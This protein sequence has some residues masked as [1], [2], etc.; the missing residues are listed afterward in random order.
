MLNKL[1][2]VAFLTFIF[3]M[4]PYIQFMGATEVSRFENRNLQQKPDMTIDKLVD[5]KY[6]EQF[7]QYFTDQFPGRNVWV[8]AYLNF[9]RYT[10]KT[11]IYDYYITDKNWIMP[12]P[13]TSY[14]TKDMKTAVK[15][16][17][18]VDKTAEK[19][20]SQLIYVSLPHKVNHVDVNKP[21]YI[22][23]DTGIKSKNYMMEQLAQTDVEVLDIGK[24][25]EKELTP[26][27]INSLYYKTD[28][29][30]NIDGAFYAFE[31]LADQLE[32][33]VDESDY[34]EKCFDDKSFEGS[35]NRQLYMMVDASNENMCIKYPEEDFDSFKVTTNGKERSVDDVFALAKDREDKLVEYKHLFTGDYAK[36]SIENPR[37]D[38]DKKVLISKDSYT[39]PMVSLIAQKFAKTDVIDLRHYKKK[40]FEQLI[41]ENDYDYVLIMINDDK[42]TGPV[43]NFD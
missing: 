6:M 29:H 30:W 26:E 35:Y 3:I 34:A 5:G 13:D 33:P 15:H 11:F 16:L 22:M 20:G 38:N 19:A 4:A 24:K 32:M 14:R 25:M 36:L 41:E 42:L 8:K 1:F 7:E 18:E 40:T 2:I 28:H 9:Q 12:K 10:D 31:K 21:S 27:E 37:A 39:N 17:E 23:E 43:Y